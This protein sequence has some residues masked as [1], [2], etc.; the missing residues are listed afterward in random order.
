MDEK[1]NVKDMDL[2]NLDDSL[3]E[4]DDSAYADADK[5]NRPSVTYW[6]LFKF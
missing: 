5:L 6:L 3:F 2:R 4:K 1:L